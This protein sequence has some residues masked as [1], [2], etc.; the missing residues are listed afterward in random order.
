MTM[1]DK[2]GIKIVMT[3]SSSDQPHIRTHAHSREVRRRLEVRFKDRDDGLKIVIVRD[4]W[5][6]G[7]DAPVVN[8]LYVDKPM[9]G[10][11]LM[12]AIARANRVFK[13]KPGGLVVDY[14]GI[15]D[16]FK[17]AL[18]EYTSS[19][20]K[21]RPTID[22]SEALAVFID[23]M[24]TLRGLLHGC[25]YWAFRTKTLSSCPRRST[26]CSSSLTRTRLKTGDVLPIT[27]WL[28]ARLCTVMHLGWSCGVPG[29]AGLLPGC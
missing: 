14:I 20:G 3:G 19:K 6:T 16:A 8:T 23:E 17:A 11:N 5:L 22:A 24:G 10:H 27:C 18:Q 26:T 7:F 1:T 15:A 9:T 12:Q 21:G 2:G 28:R 4:M 25:D 13:D 29:R